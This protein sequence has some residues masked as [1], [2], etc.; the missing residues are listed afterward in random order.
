MSSALASVAKA[1]KSWAW[2][3]LYADIV[4]R[5]GEEG[6]RVVGD[7]DLADRGEALALVLA[8]DGVLEVVAGRLERGVLALLV[9]LERGQVALQLGELELGVVEPLGGLL[10]LVE[11]PVDARLDVVD[12]GLGLRGV[13]EEPRPTVANSAIPERA[14]TIR[15][16][17]WC[18]SG[19][20]L[21]RRTPTG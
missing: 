14:V 2:R 11:E 3:S 12:V 5:L 17:P 13:A 4:E 15:F 1:S 20:L 7:D 18:T 8:D 21:G 9:G 10:G 19:G 16:R 6:A